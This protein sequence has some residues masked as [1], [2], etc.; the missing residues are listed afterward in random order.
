MYERTMRTTSSSFI[1]SLRRARKPA[2]PAVAYYRRSARKR[3]TKRF[4]NRTL[5]VEWDW[6]AG[7]IPIFPAVCHWRPGKALLAALKFGLGGSPYIEVNFPARPQMEN[8]T[9]CHN[10]VIRCRHTSIARR[11]GPSGEFDWI[12]IDPEIDFAAMY[13]GFSG[14][15][16]G[17]RF[18]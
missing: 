4:A 18:L 5:R 13:A 9:W 2:Q 17:R 8:T 15:V 10:T 7:H 6:T 1:A 3:D 14:L 16:M 11:A 12:G